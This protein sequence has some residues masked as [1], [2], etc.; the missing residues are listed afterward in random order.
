MGKLE[1]SAFQS[2][3]NRR[4]Q[5]PSQRSVPRFASRGR[6]SSRAPNIVK[7]DVE[8][9]ELHVLQ[10]ARNVM[11][12]HH[13]EIFVEVHSNDLRRRLRGASSGIRLYHPRKLYW[14]WRV[15]HTFCGNFTSPC[16]EKASMTMESAFQPGPLLRAFQYAA[17][18]HKLGIGERLWARSLARRGTAWVAFGDLRWKLNLANATHRWLVYG[19]YEEPALRQ[20]LKRVLDSK[21]VIVDSGANIGQM[22]LMY[23]ALQSARAGSCL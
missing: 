21:S 7:I 5:D 10:G 22:V 18:P 16:V 3:P 4:H 23:A 19:E 14:L 8:G 17:L 1:T 2:G 9:A 15:R 11:T 12:K 20:L 6:V 13:P